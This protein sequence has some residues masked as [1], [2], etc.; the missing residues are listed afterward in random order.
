PLV[1]RT[2]EHDEI[3]RLCLW[4]HDA[5]LEDTNR[6]MLRCLGQVEL[7]LKSQERSKLAWSQF[8]LIFLCQPTQMLFDF[9]WGTRVAKK[10]VD[11]CANHELLGRSDLGL[12]NEK[13][14]CSLPLLCAKVPAIRHEECSLDGFH[15]TPLETLGSLGEI[16]RRKYRGCY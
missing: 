1:N 16:Y 15:F 12:G 2:L 11:A 5:Q 14:E 13:G 4:I 10:N 9:R 6:R 3:C 8:D 7:T